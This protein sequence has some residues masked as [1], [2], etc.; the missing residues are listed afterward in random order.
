MSFVRATV[1]LDN[2]SNVRVVVDPAE[3]VNGGVGATINDTDGNK[4]I[5]LTTTP[6]G[7]GLYTEDGAT[8]ALS[9]HNV[10]PGEVSMTLAPQFDNSGSLAMLDPSTFGTS[11]DTANAVS[12]ITASYLAASAI[13]LYPSPDP[14]STPF[15]GM[16]YSD[17]DHHLY[18]YN[19]TT[20]KQLDN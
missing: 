6:D 16:I 7:R 11:S 10:T 19:G 12:V 18:Y 2:N 1:L 8:E 20:W 3:I 5:D 15:E 17:T 14:P 13:R 9:W 4:A